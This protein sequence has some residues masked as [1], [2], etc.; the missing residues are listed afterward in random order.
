MAKYHGFIGFA[1]QTETSP[2]IWT[3][4]IT[5]HEYS[6]DLLR[7]NR[8]AQSSG[9]TNDNLV[10][11]NE[12]SIIADAYLNEN[13]YAVRYVTF[14]GCKWKV[15]SVSIDYPRMTLSLGGIY[16]GQPS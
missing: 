12:I 8:K 16:H 5:E 13:L 15:D 11:T 10:I 1:V 9:N 2:G 7:F 6:G 4:Q 14:M 3:E